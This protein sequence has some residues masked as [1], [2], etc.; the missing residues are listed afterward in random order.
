VTEAAAFA[1]AAA[2]TAAFKGIAAAFERIAEGMVAAVMVVAAAVGVSEKSY[3]GYIFHF[4]V[5]RDISDLQVGRC[6][7][8][9]NPIRFRYI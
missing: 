3:H 4:R 9:A 1:P 6:A 5:L 2:A 8:R 7:V